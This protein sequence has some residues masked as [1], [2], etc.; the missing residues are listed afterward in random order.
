VRQQKR[1]KKRPIRFALSKN[2]PRRTEK[3]LKGEKSRKGPQEFEKGSIMKE[4][5]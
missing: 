3:C 4:M 1:R 5:D 2:K